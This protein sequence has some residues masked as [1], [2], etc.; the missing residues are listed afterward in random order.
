MPNRVMN[1][2][3]IA[4]AGGA[5]TVDLAAVATTGAYGDLTGLPTLFDGS[6]GSLTGAPTLGGAASLNVGTGA[7]TVAAGDDSRFTEVNAATTT[8]LN[9]KAP[10]ASPTFT[11]TVSGI[12]AA[13][14]GLG[15]VTNTSDA[16]KPVSTAQQTAIDAK[17][18]ALDTYNFQTGTT[19]T[20]Q[21]SDLGKIV[22]LTNAAAITVTV[23][24][25]L[26]AGF[27]CLT[28]QGGAGQVTFVAG[29][30]ATLNAYPTGAV[31]TYGIYAKVDVSVVTNA[32]GASAVADISGGS[33]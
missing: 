22:V 1:S 15:N 3:D 21:A 25:S 2:G 4:A 19:Y 30:G 26:V 17:A 13:M 11:G 14:V 32:N 10:L 18:N 33:T 24:N 6:Y 16:N 8:A 31:K 9:L 7:G 12:T 28:R 29:S 27:N 5:L 23:P 20:L